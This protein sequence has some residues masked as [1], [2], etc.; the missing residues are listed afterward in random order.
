MQSLESR[1]ESLEKRI[2]DLENSLHGRPM[3]VEA[4][5]APIPPKVPVEYVVDKKPAA[6]SSLGIGSFL[7]VLAVFCF[8]LA[9]SYIVR[10]A[11]D[12]GLLTPERQILFGALFGFSLIWTGLRLSKGDRHYASYLPAAG[13]VVLHLSA[14]GASMLYG[15]I[16]PQVS[17]LSV[18]F[19][20]LL[21][22]ALFR[23]FRTTLYAAMACIG[24]YFVPFLLRATEDPDFIGIYYVPCSLA[25]AALAVML[26]YRAFILFSGYLSMGLTNSVY[27]RADDPAFAAALL[28]LHFLIFLLGV[29]VYSVK[30][31]EPLTE[32]EALAFTP[33]LLFF[34]AIEHLLLSR[35]WPEYVDWIALGFAAF[36]NFFHLSVVRRME[37]LSLRSDVVVHAVSLVVLVHAFYLNIVPWEW[38]PLLL[39]FVLGA[40]AFSPKKLPW[41]NETLGKLC[42]IGIF[43]LLIGNY[44]GV[45]FEMLKGNELR[46]PWFAYGSAYSLALLALS[47]RYAKARE[48][49]FGIKDG[50]FFVLAAGHG[51][52]VIT[53]YA[54][55]KEH[56]SLAVSGAW[57]AYA[58]V[59]LALGFGIKSAVFARS[60]LVVLMVAAG[61]AFLY[62]VS[63]AAPLV[64]ILC[65]LLTGALLYGTGMIFQRI[66][67]W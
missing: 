6:G 41:K 19:I 59:I 54:L 64:R 7:G 43:L 34:Y 56:G 4:K 66:K 40:L 53:L 44:F 11:I 62:D 20:S 13:I 33:L 63:S 47:Y 10:L 9:G 46:F 48:S 17:I 55:A 27:G 22:V 8:V 60:S 30:H 23:N 15:V 21:C 38:K 67:E 58:L 35:I 51:Q 36:L 42:E 1:I 32:G 14:F 49:V 24:A 3:R 65:L 2:S 37:S 39:L 18:A 29:G 45:V 50:V 25:F 26:R 52:A 31:K 16:T 12:A 5:A 61:K 57:A 28:A